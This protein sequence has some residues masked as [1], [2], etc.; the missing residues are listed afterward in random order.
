MIIEEIKVYTKKSTENSK[1]VSKY[2]KHFL[3]S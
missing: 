2:K 1:Y 3:I